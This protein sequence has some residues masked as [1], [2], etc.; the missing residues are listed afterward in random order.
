MNGDVIAVIGSKGWIGEQCIEILRKRPDL[1]KIVEYSKRAD[2][3]EDLQEF[4]DRFRPT[5]VFAS[6]GRTHGSYQGKEYPTIDYLELPNKLKENINDNLF[7]IA[8]LCKMTFERG[9]HFTMVGTGCCYEYDEKHTIGGLGFQDHEE[10]NFTGS[11]YST[12]KGFTDKIARLYNHTLILRI[13]MP[14]ADFPHPRDF[15]TK[16][17]AYPKITS[18][19]NSMTV[20]S[21][22]LPAA[23]DLMIRR[24]IGAVNLVN[25]DPISHD[26][27]L[28]MYKTYIDPGHQ[29]ENVTAEEQKKMLLSGR[30]NNYLLPSLCLKKYNIPPIHKSIK[31]ILEHRR[32][33]SFIPTH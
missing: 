8:L 24:E 9:I 23:M 20:L 21:D 13:R 10:P 1:P 33:V 5:H 11:A 4:F 30:S 27:I 29:Y 19:P 28:Q 14:I 3:K 25:P 7:T 18:I 17:A 32:P 31:R 26:E 22:C 15:I 6:I 16:I 12:V 2:N